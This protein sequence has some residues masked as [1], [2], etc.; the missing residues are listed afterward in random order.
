M[1]PIQREALELAGLLL[2]AV[3]IAAIVWGAFALGGVR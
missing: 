2:C 1:T 3:L